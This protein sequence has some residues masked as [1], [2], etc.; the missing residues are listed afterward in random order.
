M[1]Q[2]IIHL[3]NGETVTIDFPSVE[4]LYMVGFQLNEDIYVKD[5]LIFARDSKNPKYPNSY[6][7]GYTIGGI[8]A[9]FGEKE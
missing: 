6:F 4:S 7:A 9:L 8:K 5:T 3:H 1:Y 2:A